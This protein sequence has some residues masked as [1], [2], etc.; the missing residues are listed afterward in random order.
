VRALRR[1]RAPP[2]GGERPP[3]TAVKALQVHSDLDLDRFGR[4]HAAATAEGASDP[5]RARSAGRHGHGER[6]GGGRDEDQE[7]Q[8]D[9]TGAHLMRAAVWLW[10]I[11]DISTS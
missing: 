3:E 5:G 7:H 2:A 4:L 6:D 1:S 9:A 11:C 10:A 8:R